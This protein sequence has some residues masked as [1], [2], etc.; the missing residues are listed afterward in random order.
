M[1][2]KNAWYCAGWDYSVS[3]AR[4]AI[5]PRMIAGERLVLFR[6]PQGQLVAFEDRCP[7]RQAALSLGRKEGDTLRCMYH[8]LR[9]ASDG[10]CVEVPER[11]RIP[12]RARVRVF[13]VVEEDN[14]IW[15]WMGDPERADETL[16]PF[17][18]GPDES[19]WTIGTSEMSVKTNYRL[20]I[21]NLADLSHLTWVHE[22]TVGG[23]RKFAAIDPELA[24]IPRGLN[25]RYWV[26]SVEPN[27]LARHLFP[28]DALFDMHFDIQHTVPCTW[29]MHF[30]M[31]T[32]G[33]ATSG[34]SDG[35][36]VLDTWT[37]QAVTPRDA[38]NVDY[39]FSW[40]VSEET[41]VPGIVDML[42]EGLDVAFR[43]D[44][45]MLEAQHVRT[46][47]KPDF[48]VVNL[49]FDEGP[50]KMLWVLDKMLRDEAKENEQTPVQESASKLEAMNASG[51]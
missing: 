44:A 28:A 2:V 31:F 27:G 20:E 12:E 11:D 37:S 15:V 47:E 35:Q 21:I 45:D 18:V 39:Y 41:E 8:G 14:W 42:R 33:T 6:T 46:Q 5:V 7:H 3:L 30:R 13:P 26:R 49:P 22:D 4:D 19:G 1:F 10:R 9:F 36:L 29:V 38:N 51:G 16:I 43:E 17:A 23:S 48:P 32:A 34:D 40:G 50:A 25:T 24:L